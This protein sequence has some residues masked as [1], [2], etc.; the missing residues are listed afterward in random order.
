[1]FTSLN[2][3]NIALSSSS[4]RIT[5]L[6]CHENTE[7]PNIINRSP[8]FEFGTIDCSSGTECTIKFDKKFNTVPLVFVMPVIDANL[9]SRDDGERITE[10]PSTVGVK[11]VT[12]SEATIYQDFAPADKAD[13]DVDFIDKDKTPVG[14]I[15]YFAIEQGV[16]ELENGSKIVSGTLPIG[17]GDDYIGDGVA[18]HYSCKKNGCNETE[19]NDGIEINFSDFGLSGGFTKT[20]GVLVQTQTTSNKDIGISEHW[21]T[22]LARDVTLRSA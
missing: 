10:Y 14:K 13:D 2:G 3:A 15:D 17:A 19:Q 7:H 22:A 20:P 8:K 11:D 1:D 21:A 4:P 6:S 9:T 12:R 16:L 5:S 18:S